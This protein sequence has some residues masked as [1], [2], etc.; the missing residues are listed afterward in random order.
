[1]QSKAASVSAYLSELA[2]EDRAALQKVRSVLRKN[3]PKGVKESVQWGMIC[4]SIPLSRY[5]DSYNGQALCYAA[6]ASQKHHNSLYLMGVYADRDADQWFR[7][8][9]KKSGKRL[10]MGKSCIRFRHAADLPLNLIG[11]A[12]AR[13]SVDD[14]IASYEKARPAK[15]TVRKKGA[16]K[17]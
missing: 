6:L 3:L 16:K 11:R 14:F 8:E 17:R 10:D 15:K 1:M 4:Y 12:V 5:S 7:G 9:F 13:T 2:P